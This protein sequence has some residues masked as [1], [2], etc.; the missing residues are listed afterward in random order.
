MTAL[1]RFEDLKIPALTVIAQEQYE[2]CLWAIERAL[3]K[4]L[5]FG[6]LLL[7]VNLKLPHGEWGNWVRETFADLKS[8]RTIQRHM[9]GAEAIATD[10]S[11]LECADSLDGILKIVE[12]R[13]PAVEV[14]ESAA[15]VLDVAEYIA[16]SDTAEEVLG[17]AS[18]NAAVERGDMSLIA[19]VETVKP[20]ASKPSNP[21]TA[22]TAKA[23]PK[24]KA[25]TV[26]YVNRTLMRLGK[27]K[28][29]G[30]TS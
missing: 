26:N 29:R 17:I 6:R 3:E 22:T 5:V 9:R 14:T 13:K 10:P 18:E 27:C 8:L 20:E 11:L 12:E 4:Q 1:I 23:G 21:T 30:T 24:S 15:S 28:K 7:I 25:P 16:D 2:D 19:A